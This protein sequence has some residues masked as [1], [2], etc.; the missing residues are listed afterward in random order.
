MN[1]LTASTDT[2]AEPVALPILS[3]L[4]N[5]YIIEND[6]S[7][8]SKVEQHMET[9]FGLAP[10]IAVQRLVPTFA[11]MCGVLRRYGSKKAEGV[12]KLIREGPAQPNIGR[13]LA[14][15]MEML[16]APQTFLT[17]DQYASV[18][19]LWMQRLHFELIGP[20]LELATDSQAE[21]TTRS[22]YSLAV[23]LMLR[24][25]TFSIYEAE[26]EKVLRI[27]IS[28]AQN[29]ESGPEVLAS[30]DV[31]QNILLEAP[32]RGQDHIRSIINI[33]IGSFTTKKTVSQENPTDPAVVAETGKL[34]LEIVGGMPRM[35][36]A[37]R[38]IPFVSQLERELTLACGHSVRELRRLARLA[39]QAWAP[40]K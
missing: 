6:A 30:L 17:K 22:N 19:P 9:A 25:M 24:H 11:I 35:F 3:V 14:R 20:M 10:D 33:C 2:R 5:K 39:R 15:R 12:L 26:A 29:L 16:V 31:L 32:E 34:A 23:I 37:R 28:T 18:K 38:L 7:L 40:L 13:S 1:A 4:S 8:V 36:E 27:S 21:A